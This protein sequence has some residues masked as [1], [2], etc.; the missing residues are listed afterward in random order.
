MHRQKQQAVVWMAA[1]SLPFWLIDVLAVYPR[2][3]WDTLVIRVGWTLLTLVTLWAVRRFLPAHRGTVGWFLTGV[4]LPNVSVAIIIGRLGGSQSPAFAWLC[5]MPLLGMSLSMGALYRSVISSAVSVVTALTLLLWEGSSA[6]L[7]ATWG[8]LILASGF[9]AVQAAYFYSRMKTARSE[10]ESHRRIAE[11]AL[12]VTQSRVQETD[13]L[14][15]VGKLAAGVAHEVNNPLSFIQ[16]N[17]R[18]L[19]EELPRAERDE[20][21]AEQAALYPGFADYEKKT[22]RVIPVLALTRR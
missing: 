5:V 9:V 21:Y 6:T 17:L 3:P 1:S 16:A 8:L 11:E 4:L 10:A 18:F 14:A 22:D 13:R 15:Q 2:V 12:E 20:K 19:A 7:V